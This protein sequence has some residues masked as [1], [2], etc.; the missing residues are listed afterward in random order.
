MHTFIQTLTCELVQSK[1][2]YIYMQQEMYIQIYLI[3]V[4]R[5]VRYTQKQ[6]HSYSCKQSIHRADL[7]TPPQSMPAQPLKV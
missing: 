3:S 5:M 2:G 7:S 4:I 1:K 6:V